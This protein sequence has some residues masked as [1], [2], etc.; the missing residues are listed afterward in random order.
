MGNAHCCAKRKS[1]DDDLET[2]KR[3][4]TPSSD[5]Q[6][7]ICVK[8]VDE[9]LHAQ[10][11][12]D[13]NFNEKP[14]DDGQFYM[15]NNSLNTERPL[16][17]VYCSEASSEETVSLDDVQNKIFSPPAF[18][19]VESA[20][21]GDHY[22]S[23]AE[24][25][26]YESAD[27][28]ECSVDLTADAKLEDIH[29]DTI[30][31]PD[32]IDAESLIESAE[33]FMESVESSVEVVANDTITPGEVTTVVVSEWE[34]SDSANTPPLSPFRFKMP[35]QV[36][37]HK[38]RRMAHDQVIICNDKF[39]GNRSTPGKSVQL[40]GSLIGDDR[41]IKGLP[42]PLRDNLL[43]PTRKVE[44]LCDRAGRPLADTPTRK[45]FDQKRAKTHM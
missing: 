9:V 35:L 21:V 44:E 33:L 13:I 12:T 2:Y 23:A 14:T 42:T 5:L 6:H 41:Q 11:P 43:S 19:T 26:N 39:G 15:I 7:G 20:G 29:E 27:E 17:V 34:S 45:Y 37:T 1:L 38:K 16:P 3:A 25:T 18:L 40:R 32:D 10:L 30:L 28:D 24:T 31:L 36:D 4:N 8:G 22:L